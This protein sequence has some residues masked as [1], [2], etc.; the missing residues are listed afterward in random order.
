MTN[1]APFEF[2]SLVDEP[3]NT[4]DGDAD[5]PPPRVF[6][7]DEVLAI[8]AEAEAT[9]FARAAEEARQT[10]ETSINVFM[11]TLNTLADDLRAEMTEIEK[12]ITDDAVNLARTLAYKIGGEALHN[13]P[14]TVVEQ[15][16]TTTLKE[17][18]GAHRLNITVHEILKP[19]IEARIAETAGEIGFEGGY[20]VRTGGTHM[21]DCAIEWATG[22]VAR[23]HNA[24]VTSI[25]RLIEAHGYENQPG[26]TIEVEPDVEETLEFDFCETGGST[27]PPTGSGDLS[28]G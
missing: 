26:P 6:S 3:D 5:L 18:T 7:E 22:R 1:L 14:L 25:E 13:D 10:N 20:H 8:R 27:I 4:N 15:V 19:A 28:D 23:D 9:G 21:A 17:I 12:Q 16:I 2:V 11:E 24:L